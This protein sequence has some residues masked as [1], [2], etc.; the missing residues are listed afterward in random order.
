MLN[1]HTR[2][3]TYISSFKLHI[4]SQ[5]RVHSL[6]AGIVLYSAIPHRACDIVWFLQQATMEFISSD[7]TAPTSI[8]WH[9]LPVASWMICLSVVCS[10][11][12]WTAEASVGHLVVCIVIMC[13]IGTHY[14]AVKTSAACSNIIKMWWEFCWKFHPL[15]NSEKCL[16][17]GYDLVKLLSKLSIA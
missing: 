2:P 5:I 12:Q 4:S 9:L 8:W 15:F 7:Q 3:V 13:S 14:I 17:T 11:C 10:K 16:K 6:I 1:F